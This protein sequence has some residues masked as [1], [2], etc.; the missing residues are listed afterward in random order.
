MDGKDI[1]CLKI[2]IYG[3]HFKMYLKGARYGENRCPINKYL[4]LSFEIME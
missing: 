1:N 4:M 2:L 3:M